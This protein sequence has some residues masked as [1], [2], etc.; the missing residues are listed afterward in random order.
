MTVVMDEEAQKKADRNSKQP[1]EKAAWRVL[2]NKL[3]LFAIFLLFVD[4]YQGV[5]N[6]KAFE[7]AMH[8]KELVYIKM[9][10]GGES[11]VDEFLPRDKPTFYKASIDSALERY[12][13]SR[14]GV[15]PE[16]VKKDFGIAGVFMSQPMYNEFISQQKGGF[17]AVQKAADIQAN[18]ASVPR[19][20]IRWGFPNHY[21]SVPGVVGKEKAEI[22]RTNV[23]FTEVTKSPGGLIVKDGVKK[24]IWRG[25]WRLLSKDELVKKSKDWLRVNPIGLEVIQADVIDDPAGYQTDE[26]Q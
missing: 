25:Q 15:Q 16:T 6:R 1:A 3:W 24:K 22:F 18:T 10:P 4:V 20:E 11:T 8:S 5:S 26:A 12:L 14:Y 23:Y 13:M 21:D 9:G 2:N 7:A 19:V 17:N